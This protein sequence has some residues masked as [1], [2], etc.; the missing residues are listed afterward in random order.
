MRQTTKARWNILAQAVIVILLQGFTACILAKLTT[1][2]PASPPTGP[3]APVAPPIGLEESD[4]IAY[5][6]SCK[7]EL[8]LPADVLPPWNCLAGIELPVTINEQPLTEANYKQLTSNQV[9]C[10]RPSWLGSIPCS[11]YGFVQHRAL[12][13]DVDAYMICRDQSFTNYKDR[14]TR[15]KDLL[16]SSGV[17]SFNS[18]FAFDSLGM[19]WTSKTSGKTCFFDFVGQVYGGYVPSPDDERVPQYSELPDPKPPTELSTGQIAANVWG[20]NARGAWRAP[21][22]VANGDSCIV[23]HDNGPIK[24]SPWME[25]AIKVPVTPPNLPYLVVGKAFEV[26]KQKYPIRA[27]STAPLS[28]GKGG[29]TP[30]ACTVCHRIGS[31]STCEYSM[32]YSVGKSSPQAKVTGPLN[33]A[34]AVWMPPQSDAD[35]AK[36]FDVQTQLFQSNYGAHYDRLACCCKNPNAI[37]CTS[38]DVT[39]SPIGSVVAGTGPDVC[40]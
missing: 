33:W 23:C 18:Y 10:D 37:N 26:W 7:R 24:G 12:S 30:Q 17:D 25:Q 27:I 3:A 38:Q 36:G 16:A 11:N 14:A 2:A 39:V 8:K 40:P 5:A 34:H 9:G 20:R 22:A 4:V 13:D 6:Q 19:I 32:S 15:L 29:T 1:P 35:K 31:Q 28:D 21:N